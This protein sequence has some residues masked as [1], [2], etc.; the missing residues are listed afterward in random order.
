MDVD[1][2]ATVAT[3]AVLRSGKCYD[4]LVCVVGLTTCAELN[5]SKDV[6]IS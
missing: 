1:V 3:I 2:L 6:G 4:E 5:I